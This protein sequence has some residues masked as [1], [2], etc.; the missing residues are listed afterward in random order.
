MD[1]LE[2]RYISILSQDCTMDEQSLMFVHVRSSPGWV[3]QKGEGR[4][5][6]C[7]VMKGN[8]I[9]PQEDVRE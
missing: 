1:I 3:M 9:K 4:V 8:N 7:V 5:S 6:C 2:I